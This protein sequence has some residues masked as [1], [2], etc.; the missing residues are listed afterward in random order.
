[1]DEV[2]V[3]RDQPQVRDLLPAELEGPHLSQRQQF[4]SAGFH[5]L[6]EHRQCD[7]KKR[8]LTGKNVPSG[9]LGG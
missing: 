1:M 8:W 3:L 4:R 9:T 6:N 2:L 5:A 7:S